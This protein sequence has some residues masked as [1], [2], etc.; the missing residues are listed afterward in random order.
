[1]ITFQLRRVPY[2]KV[3]HRVTWKWATLIVRYQKHSITL[4]MKLK[5]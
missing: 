5:Q 1:M 3:W 2:M 4:K